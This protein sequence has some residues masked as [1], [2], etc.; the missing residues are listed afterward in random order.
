[1][2]MTPLQKDIRL[3]RDSSHNRTIQILLAAL[4]APHR[5]RT[6]TLLLCI[7]LIPIKRCIPQLHGP[8][9]LQCVLFLSDPRFIPRQR[10][11]AERSTPLWLVGRRA[12]PSSVAA[13]GLRFGGGL[14]EAEASGD[15]AVEWS[16]CC[17]TAGG[18]GETLFDI[19]PDGDV[20]CVVEEVGA[21][22]IHYEGH[23][24]DDGCAGSAVGQ[25]SSPEWY[26]NGCHLHASH[27]QDGYQHQLRISGHVQIPDH[28]DRQQAECEVANR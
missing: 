10:D 18:N 11:Q 23:A 28:E 21:A 3:S 13:F 5:P 4:A 20:H 24:D 7:P 19:G 6:K 8:R 27:A 22:E 26:G 17:E 12:V 25:S 15:N 9:I 2:Q 1:M 14:R 16:Q